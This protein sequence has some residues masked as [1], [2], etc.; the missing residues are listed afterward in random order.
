MI[1]GGIAQSFHN[2]PY[3][4]VGSSCCLTAANGNNGYY[5]CS[6]EDFAGGSDAVAGEDEPWSYVCA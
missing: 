2:M 1:A 4:T 6:D 5:Y 3:L